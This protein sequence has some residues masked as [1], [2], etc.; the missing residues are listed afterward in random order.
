MPTIRIG[1][2]NIEPGAYEVTL[3]HVSQPKTI[4]PQNDPDGVEILEWT[5][6]LDDGQQLTDSTSMNSGPRSKMYGWLTALNSGKAPS[7]DEDIDTDDLI[8]RRVIANVTLSEKGWPKIG[9]LS[10]IPVSV[11]QKRFAQATQ[12]PT[13]PTQRPSADAK[14]D[15]VPF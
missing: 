13:R 10:A 12:A 4:Y 7:T 2:G 1:A 9:S 3:Q 11:Q 5:F 8:G 6:V 15:G 14:P